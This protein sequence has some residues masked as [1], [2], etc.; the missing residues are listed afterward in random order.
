MFDCDY[1][2]AF[3]VIGMIAITGSD[4]VAKAATHITISLQYIET[5]LS[6]RLITDGI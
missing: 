6:T 1:F 2:F 3:W 5:S 4:N